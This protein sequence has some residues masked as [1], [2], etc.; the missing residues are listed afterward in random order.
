LWLGIEPGNVTSITRG[1]LISLALGF[2]E[3]W[4]GQDE[5]LSI[6]LV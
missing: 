6:R 5:K 3:K 1:V 2:D 4:V